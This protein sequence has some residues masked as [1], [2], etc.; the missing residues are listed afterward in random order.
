MNSTSYIDPEAVKW[1]AVSWFVI[2][3]AIS[4]LAVNF[5]TFA[6]IVRSRDCDSDTALLMKSLTFFDVGTAISVLI[7]LPLSQFFG[8]RDHLH[9][10][11]ANEKLN[12]LSYFLFKPPWIGSALISLH[13]AIRCYRELIKLLVTPNAG[14]SLPNT[15][16]V[17][18]VTFYALIG[19]CICTF[20][21]LTSYEVV[22]RYLII[23]CSVATFALNLAC[24]AKALKHSRQSLRGHHLKLSVSA[25]VYL[26]ANGVRVWILGHFDHSDYLWPVKFDVTPA[27]ANP[28][29]AHSVIV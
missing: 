1:S 10:Q 12:V 24:L 2:A 16:T 27:I 25:V 11:F 8:M 9:V 17:C 7:F 26:S 18:Y 19:V 15:C 6:A 3:E 21:G 14:S 5:W 20:W 23:V 29:F 22:T 13:I 28:L 4:A